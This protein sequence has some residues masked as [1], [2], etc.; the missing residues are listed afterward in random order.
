MQKVIAARGELSVSIPKL[1]IMPSRNRPTQCR[2]GRIEIDPFTPMVATK[3]LVMSTVRE[4][5]NGGHNATVLRRFG[6]AMTI[7]E[8]H[9]DH[10]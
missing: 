10:S 1:D 8:A 6:S 9:Y 7:W 5:V 4:R 3:S 2:F